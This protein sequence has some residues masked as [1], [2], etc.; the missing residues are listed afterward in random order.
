VSARGAS[1][2]RSTFKLSLSAEQRA[3]LP[4]NPV[5]PVEIN[6]AQLFAA[7]GSQPIEFTIVP[8]S[9][10]FCPTKS[11]GSLCCDVEIP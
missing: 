5:G 1:R 3:A 10:C 8:R 11:I 4:E 9:F 6:D 7:G 2:A